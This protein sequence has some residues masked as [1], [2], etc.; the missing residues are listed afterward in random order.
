MLLVLPRYV[1]IVEFG[2]CIGDIN[3]L[4]C[5][6]SRTVW[7]REPEYASSATNESQPETEDRFFEPMDLASFTIELYGTLPSTFRF[8]NFT[9][10]AA[11]REQPSIVVARRNQRHSDR[12]PVLAL[13]TWNVNYWCVQCL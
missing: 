8:E 6:S 7:S 13:K 9:N 3:E 12:H 11:D 10:L 5:E 4:D 2:E 1:V